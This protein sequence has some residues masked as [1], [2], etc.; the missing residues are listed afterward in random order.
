[1]FSLEELL[2]DLT[3][4]IEFEE[5][6]KKE[7]SQ[8]NIRFWRACEVLKFLPKSQVADQVKQIYK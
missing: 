2:S 1:M 3:G 4:R 6:L 5:F 7:Y 8:E